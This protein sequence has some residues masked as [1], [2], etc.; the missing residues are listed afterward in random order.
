MLKINDIGEFKPVEIEKILES[1]Q[2]SRTT[3]WRWMY[4]IDNPF[5]FF[6][7]GR[8]IYFDNDDIIKWYEGSR[9]RDTEE[10]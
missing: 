4:K 8:K 9:N 6:R 2:I 10:L 1:F 3:L 7:L 5:P